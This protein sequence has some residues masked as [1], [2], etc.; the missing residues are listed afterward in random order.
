MTI[1]FDTDAD[2]FVIDPDHLDCGHPRYDTCCDAPGCPGSC[3]WECGTG[4]D[5]EFDKNGRCATAKAAESDEDHTARINRERAAFG[6][7]PIDEEP[8][9]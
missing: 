7:S 6:L 4:C 3:C 9:P 5:A 1:R 2:S 8:Q